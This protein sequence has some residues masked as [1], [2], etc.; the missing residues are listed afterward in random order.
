MP[1]RSTAPIR[2]PWPMRWRASAPC[3]CRGQGPALLDVEC[4]RS[5]GHSTTDANVYRTQGGDAAWEPL[6]PIRHM[7]RRAA[8]PKASSTRRGEASMRERGRAADPRASPRAAVD[9][10]AAPIVDIA[11][12]PDADRPP[13]VL[14]PEIAVPAGEPKLLAAPETS[15]RIRQDAKKSRTGLG[16]DGAKLS[17][18][19]RDHAARRAV[20]GDPPPHDPRRAPHRLWRGVPRMGRRL[21][22]LSRPLRHPALRAPVQ[23][24]DLGSGHRRHRRGPCAWKAAA[25]WSN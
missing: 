22:R 17:A 19:A 18:D 5:T 25:R 4:Y 3:S 1:R 23:F 20:R 10:A 12:R 7:P 11:G 16:P 24:A 15:A 14:R 13:D 9:P 8:W 21:R 6:D 2:S